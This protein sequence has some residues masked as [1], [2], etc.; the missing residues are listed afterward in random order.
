M[1]PHERPA[2]LDQDAGIGRQISLADN[3]ADGAFAADQNGFDVAAVLVGD[4][5][6]RKSR[7]ARKVDDFDIVAGIVKQVAGLGLLVGEMRRNQRKVA[8]AEP[9]QQIVERTLDAIQSMS[10]LRCHPQSPHRPVLTITR[11]YRSAVCTSAQTPKVR[12]VGFPKGNRRH[13]KARVSVM[14]PS[15]RSKS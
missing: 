3:S 5:I 14:S 8:G 13:A 6:G 7:S 2:E 1:Q 10:L 11:S 4:Q 15:I 9:P 12:C